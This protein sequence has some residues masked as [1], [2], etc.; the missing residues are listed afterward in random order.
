[1]GL[2]NWF[3]KQNTEDLLELPTNQKNSFVSKANITQEKERSFSPQEI[4]TIEH[5]VITL[6][7]AK[8]EKAAINHACQLLKTG[9]YL[10]A[11]YAF[12]KIMDLLPAQKGLCENQIGAAYFFLHQYQDAFNHYLL[13]L[14]YN[15]DTKMLDYN[16]WEAAEAYFKITGDH[17]LVKIYLNR[18]PNGDFQQAA[19]ELS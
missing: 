10:Q 18:F 4:E 13:S 14:E 15:F 12:Q 7:N 17:S 5:K 6:L 3:K 11:V 9:A 8:G 1:M 2:F 19:Q 16:L